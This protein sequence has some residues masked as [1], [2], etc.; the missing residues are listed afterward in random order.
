MSN[1]DDLDEATEVTPNAGQV[2]EAAEAT[3]SL[4]EIGDAMRVTPAEAVGTSSQGAL[5]RPQKDVRRDMATQKRAITRTINDLTGYLYTTRLRSRTLLRMK[6]REV[7]DHL[8]C[9]NEIVRG[10]KEMNEDENE[11]SKVEDYLHEQSTRVMEIKA[12]VL[13]HLERRMDEASTV[14]GSDQAKLRI[15]RL[16]EKQDD[17]T[18]LTEVQNREPLQEADHDKAYDPVTSLIRTE[19]HVLRQRTK[20]FEDESAIGNEDEPTHRSGPRPSWMTSASIGTGLGSGA[21]TTID[22]KMPKFNGDV[23]QFEEWSNAFQ[24]LVHETNKSPV[25]KMGLLKASLEG[26]ARIL[27]AGYGNKSEHYLEALRV[28]GEVYGDPVLLVEAHQREIEN[29]PKVK[30]RDLVSLSK[31]SFSLQ[32]HLLTVSEMIGEGD[33]LWGH[34]VRVIERKL[35]QDTYFAWDTYAERLPDR[36]RLLGLSKWLLERVKKLRRFSQNTASGLTS[37]EIPINLSRS[38]TS[39]QVFRVCPQCNGDH[40]VVD[41]PSFKKIPLP[42]RMELV[43]SK[44]LCFGCLRQGHSLA[45]CRNKQRCGV[46]NCPRYHQALIHKNIGTDNNGKDPGERASTNSSNTG[47]SIILGMV[48]VTCYG[49]NGRVVLNALIDGGS[50]TTFISESAIKRVGN[51]KGK[52]GRLVVNGASG[53][54]EFPSKIFNIDVSGVKGGRFRIRARTHPNVC[55]GLVGSSWKDVKG[56]WK[57][58]KDLNLSTNED[59]VQMLIGLDNGHLIQPLEFRHGSPGDPYAFRTRLGWVC[60]GQTEGGPSVKDRLVNFTHSIDQ[61]SGVVGLNECL[62]RFFETESYGSEGTEGQ[63]CHSLQD[64]YALEMIQAGIQKLE[65]GPGYEVALPW[66]PGVEKPKNN[67]VVA[68]KRLAGLEKRFLQDP[69]FHDAYLKAIQ[70]TINNGYAKLVED[71][72]E[73]AHPDQAFLPHHGVWKKDGKKVRV[74][75]D[76]AARFHGK[77]L[78]DCLLTGPSV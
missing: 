72:L 1:K 40:R 76:S 18:N 20:D 73:L 53:S 4:N 5:P 42:G 39:T 52:E 77:S 59:K 26:E 38:N 60:R 58:L 7:E 3:A 9:L 6:L 44:N 17:Q 45:E 50:D 46:D 69:T 35:D 62:H 67:K 24:S 54:T 36:N 55:Q 16:V 61:E 49:P 28:L 34:L 37:K 2:G 19:E 48:P 29:L 30:A 65:T 25:E 22:V 47:M 75:F 21:R 51:I 8:L 66:I 56:R 14:F 57:H 41:C 33:S 10:H 15:F 71:S 70:T 27:I 74:V 64:Q 78:N 13:D 31:F 11:C 23:I 68:E 12:E 43:L 63:A 32:G